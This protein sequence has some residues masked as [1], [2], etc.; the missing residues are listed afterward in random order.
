M[1][2]FDIRVYRKIHLAGNFDKTLYLRISA[3]ETIKNYGMLMKNCF[4]TTWPQFWRS[5]LK[6]RMLIAWNENII[7]YKSDILRYDILSWYRRYRSVHKWRHL[8]FW[9]FRPPPPVCHLPSLLPHPPR[10]RHLS[11]TPLP[12]YQDDF[13]QNFI[14]FMLKFKNDEIRIQLRF[15]YQSNSC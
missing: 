7:W 10:W 8:K 9:V 14:F 4:G 15:K 2:L 6:N 5:S 13:K 1:K 11:T 12:F 3:N